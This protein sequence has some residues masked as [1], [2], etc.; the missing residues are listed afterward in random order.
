MQTNQLLTA[1]ET[2]SLAFTLRHL[3]VRQFLDKL[4]G[5]LGGAEHAEDFLQRAESC[6][7]DWQKGALELEKRTILGIRSYEA[8]IAEHRRSVAVSEILTALSRDRQARQYFR[9]VG[10][11]LHPIDVVE[12]LKQESLGVVVGK[13]YRGEEFFAP[14]PLVEFKSRCARRVRAVEG[15]HGR[16]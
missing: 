3:D 1:V 11:P 4:Q 12:S 16:E 6:A 5:C 14:V 7:S 15:A 2:A 10:T 13:D 9:K 8:I